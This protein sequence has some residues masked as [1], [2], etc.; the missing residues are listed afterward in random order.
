M[1]TVSIIIPAFNEG[2]FIAQLLDKIIEVPTESIG[3]TKE[4]IVVDDGSTDNT[5][6]VA[7]G[8]AGVT[9]IKQANSGK[10]RAVQR[11]VQ[12]CTGDY[13]LVQDAD[14]EYSPEDYLLLLPALTADNNTAVYGSRPLGVIEK[15]G[16]KYP[17]P[18]RDPRQQLGPWIMNVVLAIQTF[19]LYGRWITDMLT[20]YKV[21][22]SAIIKDFNIKTHGFETDHELSAKLVKAGVDIVEI[23]IS[24]TPR[25]LAEGKKIRA[26]DGLIAIWTL[27]KYRFVN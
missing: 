5:F 22:P 12:D 2:A 13:V 21:Y 6:A 1:K 26:V 7:S 4:I 25:S 24:Y 9:V 19:S 14:L 10:G 3:F 11:G 8:F 17:F 18:G 20:G 27:I 15:H 16:W 23:P